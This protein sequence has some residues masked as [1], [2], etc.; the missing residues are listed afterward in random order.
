MTL[1]DLGYTDALERY[2]TEHGLGGFET[3]RVVAEHKE[4][5]VVRTTDGDLEAEIIGKLRAMARDRH[6]FPAVGDWVAIKVHEP[7]HATIHHVYPRSSVIARKAIGGHGGDQIIAANIDHAFLVQALDQDFNINRLERYLT[8][9]HASGVGP[10]IVLTK[11]DL[12]E[13]EQVEQQKEQVRARIPNVPLIALSNLQQDGSEPLQRMMEHGKT[14][15]LLGSSGA[16]KSSLINNLIGSGTMLT[17]TI[18]GSTGKGR[19]ITSHRELFV[20][21]TGGII[22]DNPGMREVGVTDVE[23]G[24]DVTFDAIAALA[25]NCKFSDCTHT[26]EV[27]CAVLSALQRGELDEA[28]YANYQKMKDEAAHYRTTVAERRGK[29]K[30]FWKMLKRYKKDL[31]KM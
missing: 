2:R 13:P 27:G 24:L 16:G 21:P 5:Y 22:I 14:Y 8:I 6:D 23:R 3:G 30:A 4:R 9:C 20:M 31:G 10:I 1:E 7:G 19:H 12:F 26:S 15:C 11:T 17:G 29:D 25:K 18:S 28:S